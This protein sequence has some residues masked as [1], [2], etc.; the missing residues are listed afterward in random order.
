[1]KPF[2]LGTAFLNKNLRNPETVTF[3][4]NAKV[5]NFWLTHL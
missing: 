3:Y 2:F 5:I 4:A 1:M